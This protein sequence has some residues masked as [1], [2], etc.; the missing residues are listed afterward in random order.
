[1]ISN[2]RRILFLCCLLIL[3]L[4]CTCFAEYSPSESIAGCRFARSYSSKELLTN[5]T[6]RGL[7]IRDVFHWE[8]NFAKNGVG[9]NFATGITYDGHGI[10][11]T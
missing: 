4:S 3:S 5:T 6:A 9:L 11:Y 1:M 2:I 7:F 10:N 8:G